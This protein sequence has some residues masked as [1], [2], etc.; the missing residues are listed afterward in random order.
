MLYEMLA[1]EPPFTGPSAQI[2][3]AKRFV[4]PTPRVRALRETVPE[5]V[6]RVI[7][8]ALEKA[9][10]D[11]FLT[12]AEF[13]A[14][15]NQPTLVSDRP[16]PKLKGSRRQWAAILALLTLLLSGAGYLW[17]RLGGEG[18]TTAGKLITVAILPFRPLFKTADTGALSIGIP[19]AIITRLANVRQLRVRP[20][21]SIIRYQGE[22]PEL[23]AVAK[24][25]QTDYVLNGT[26]EPAGERLRVSVQLLRARD[27]ELLWGDHY[28]LARQD[29]LTLQDSIAQRVSSA[30]AIR[31]SDEE[32]ARVYRHYTSNAAA[33]ERYLAG[34]SQ[35][36]T[37]TREGTLA[38]IDN[39]ERALQLDPNYALARAGL[40][41]ASADMHL[42]FASGPEVK[43]WGARAEQEAR[44]A[45]ALDPNLAEAHLA[46]AAVYRKA[47]FN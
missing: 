31:M 46:M 37:L 15:L 4:E 30:L 18:S 33:F 42:R 38:G 34:R 28:D 44:H 16:Q 1:G 24:A 11:R 25:L 23:S 29:L 22:T 27:G 21:S 2:V 6:E 39:F 12:G 8:K 19:D 47:E 26:L 36:A 43:T 7:L 5:P 41:M 45:L 14:G 9:P 35:L 17:Y 10:A 20:T 32:R 3:V 40:A 13:A